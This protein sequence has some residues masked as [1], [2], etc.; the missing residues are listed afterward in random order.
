MTEMAYTA[1]ADCTQSATL[2]GSGLQPRL[3]EITAAGNLLLS[4][5][6][7]AGPSHELSIAIT[8]VETGLLWAQRGMVR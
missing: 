7:D 1:T 5:L 3:A 8:N 6:R 2:C 4:L